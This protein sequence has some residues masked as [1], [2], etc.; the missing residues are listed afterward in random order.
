M[1]F[2]LTTISF[3][4]LF[5]LQINAQIVSLDFPIGNA[6]V[7]LPFKTADNLILIDT[8]LNGKRGL[9]IFDTGAESTVVNSSFAQKVGL[10]TR[11]TTVGNGSAGSATA[12]IIRGV[13][14][15]L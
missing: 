10:K 2:S 4:V 5:C 1:R 13:E 15:T 7:T 8:A 9:F 11:G 12:G 6:R 3:A 14:L